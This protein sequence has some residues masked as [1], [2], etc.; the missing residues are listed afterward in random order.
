[1]LAIILTL[2][3]IIAI[4]LAVYFVWWSQAR[5]T[6]PAPQEQPLPSQSGPAGPQG[7][8]GPAGPQGEPGQP[9][10]SEPTTPGRSGM[11]WEPVIS[12]VI[13]T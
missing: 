8:P 11:N 10:P 3:I 13:N 7:E 6:Q 1:L 4:G 2:L 9:A 5:V 12:P